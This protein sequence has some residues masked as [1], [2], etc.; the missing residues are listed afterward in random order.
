VCVCVHMIYIM[1]YAM[2]YTHG[3]CMYTYG[4]IYIHICFYN[5]KHC[6]KG[7]CSSFHMTMYVCVCMCVHVCVYLCVAGSFLWRVV[8]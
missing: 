8:I 1:L 6:K 2:V 5:N 4:N 7:S 3:I